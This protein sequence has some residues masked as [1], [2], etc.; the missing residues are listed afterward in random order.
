M[1]READSVVLRLLARSSGEVKA[2]SRA[3]ALGSRSESW[4]VHKNNQHINHNTE[5]CLSRKR[6]MRRF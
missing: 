5:V 4:S 6:D 2:G 1:L 3:R